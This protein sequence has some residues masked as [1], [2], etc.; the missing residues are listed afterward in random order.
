M[1]AVISVCLTHYNRPEKLGA[2]LESLARQTRAPDEV[3]V[4]DDCSPNDPT[5]VVAAFKH[6]FKKFIYE[7]NEKNLGMPGNLNKVV[8]KA[9][10]DFIANLHDADEFHPQL[11]EKWEAVLSRYP[12]AG[13]AFCGLDAQSKPTVLQK[14]GRIWIYDFEECTPGHDFFESAYVGSSSSPI[15][16]TVMVRREVYEQHL[17]FGARFGLWSDVDMW[18]RVC[19][20]HD[21]AYVPEPL[22]ILDHT[23]TLARSFHWNKVFITHAMHFENIPRIARDLSERSNWLSRQRRHSLSRYVRHLGGRVLRGDLVGLSAGVFLFPRFVAMVV[24]AR[25]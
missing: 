11:L 9:T 15:W 2:T 16:G 4:Q 10:G 12:S 7:R 20:T 1:T 13:L 6:R 22:I 24:R 5:E 14:P 23:D 8:R 19:G 3:F 17:P 25:L 21:I 18:M